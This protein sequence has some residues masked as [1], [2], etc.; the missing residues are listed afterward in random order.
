MNFYNFKDFPVVPFWSFFEDPHILTI[1]TLHEDGFRIE[2]LLPRKRKFSECMGAMLA[3]HHDPY[4][5][6]GYRPFVIYFISLPFYPCLAGL[7]MLQSR[8]CTFSYERGQSVRL[9]FPYNV[10]KQHGVIVWCS[11][12][13][14]SNWMRVGSDWGVITV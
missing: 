6:R 1:G 10:L 12:I 4:I 7:H 11:L 3:N 13:S 14:P 8:S 9:E 5:Q 2:C